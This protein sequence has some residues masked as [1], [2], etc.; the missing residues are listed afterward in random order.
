[1]VSSCSS[2]VAQSRLGCGVSE[3]APY[4]PN[5]PPPGVCMMKMSPEAISTLSFPVSCL[6][7]PSLRWT[8]FSPGFP[9]CPPARPA[10]TVMRCNDRTVAVMGSRNANFRVIHINREEWDITDAIRE[11]PPAG[12]P[13]R[14]AFRTQRYRTRRLRYLLPHRGRRSCAADDRAF[15]ES[16]RSRWA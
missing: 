1:M 2:L 10:G 5:P 15:Q 11:C 14:T 9:G 4:L 8:R 16:C 13:R 3:P 12:S 6:T 7:D